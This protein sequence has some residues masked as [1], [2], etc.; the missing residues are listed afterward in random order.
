[1][2]A[3]AE[4]LKSILKAAGNL[5]E[6]DDQVASVRPAPGKWSKK[7]IL[8][9]LIDSAANN[10]QRFVRLQ[11]TPRLELPGYDGDAWVSLQHYQERPWRDIIDLW[12]VYNTQLAEVIRYVNPQSLRNTWRAPDGNDVDLE[13]IIRDY[14]VHMRHHLDQILVQDL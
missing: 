13:F 5:R 14:L 6:I 1:M 7:E 9:H 3:V 2:Q 8:G 12:L 11:L 4:E 10:H